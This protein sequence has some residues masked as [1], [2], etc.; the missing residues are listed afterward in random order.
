MKTE[1]KAKCSRTSEQPNNPNVPSFAEVSIKVMIALVPVL[2]TLT[3]PGGDPFSMILRTV[4]IVALIAGI[5]PWVIHKGFFGVRR[6]HQYAKCAAIVGIALAIAFFQLLIPHIVPS[7]PRGWVATRAAENQIHAYFDD[8]N[9]V[10]QLPVDATFP[11]VT[12]KHVRAMER[13][14]SRLSPP[15]QFGS[16]YSTLERMGE[17]TNDLTTLRRRSPNETKYREYE[18]AIGTMHDIMHSSGMQQVVLAFRKLYPDHT[19]VEVMIGPAREVH[20]QRARLMIFAA[21]RYDGEYL[22]ADKNASPDSAPRLLADAENMLIT[23]LAHAINDNRYPVAPDSPRHKLNKVFESAFDIDD[24]GYALDLGWRRLANTK[25][26]D[27][28]NA[29]RWEN[30]FTRQLKQPRKQESL[31]D[32]YEIILTSYPMERAFE[33]PTWEQFWRMENPWRIGPSGDSRLLIRQR[34]EEE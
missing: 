3:I 31:V 29:D 25:I 8:L 32:G 5:I 2:A 15:R 34:K 19:S 11:D 30:I 18:D 28:R 12:P 23:D 9:T 21:V 22:I 17:Q 27:Y 26:G 1:Q 7:Y 6:F 20:E 10:L 13:L 16:M 33:W 14:W 4:I 24:Y